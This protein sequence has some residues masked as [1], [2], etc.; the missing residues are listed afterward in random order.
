MESIKSG[1]RQRRRYL[2]LGLIF[3]AVLIIGL[4]Y[5]KWWPYFQKAVAAS[6]THAIGGAIIANIGKGAAP[7][8]LL[9][10]WTF[11]LAYFKA[12]WK[13]VILGLLVGSLVQ[14][15]IPNR[16]IQRYLGGSQFKNSLAAMLMGVPTMMC[17]CCTA[18]VAV[19]LKRSKASV[20]SVVAFFLAN[21]LLNPATLV[22][23]GFVLG[24]NFVVFRIV[25]GLIAVL[26]LA[27]L[28][29]KLSPKKTVG[30]PDNKLFDPIRENNGRLLQRWGKALGRLVLESIPAYVV[31][32]FILGAFQGLLF[33]AIN[34]SLD[35][36]L[37]A[38]VLFAV[39]GTIFVLPTAGEIPIIQVLMAMGLSGGPAAAL[40]IA[41]PAVSVVSLA[42]LKPALSWRSLVTIGLGVM[43]ISAFAGLVGA[44]IL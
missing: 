36:G 44:V 34:S 41:L 17:T 27:T 15:L 11:T 37:L 32:V 5:V 8:S 16:V 30:I 13:A 10:G 35:G 3:L 19:G 1:H 42:L 9:A 31:I 7:F 18:P 12:V 25:F 6:Q 21:P 28:V 20:N 24:W 40:L 33:P 39:V 4:F 2:I 14:V 38:I 23:M 22:F 43:V 29:G 26:G